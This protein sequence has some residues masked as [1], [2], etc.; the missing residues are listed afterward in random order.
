MDK[1]D[2]PGA[3]PMLDGRFALNG[4]PDIVEMLRINQS[5]QAMTFGKPIEQSFPM[6]ESA[7]WQIARNTGVQNAVAPI[8]HKINPAARHKAK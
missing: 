5:L 3:G 2:L 6:L 8:G 7:P 4:I 1:A